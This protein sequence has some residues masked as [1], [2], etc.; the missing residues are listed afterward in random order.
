MKHNS[1]TIFCLFFLF[2]TPLTAHASVKLECIV[3][4]EVTYT[5]QKVVS[6]EVLPPEKVFVTINDQHPDISVRL[7]SN[8]DYSF[9]MGDFLKPMKVINH[10]DAKN[11]RWSY[12]ENTVTSQTTGE[13]EIDRALWRIRVTQSWSHKKEPLVTDTIFFGS[14]LH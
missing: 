14:C 3:S 7:K 10:S 6:V 2:T 4:G 11:F 12:S 9:F 1:I 5:D 13:I 8:A